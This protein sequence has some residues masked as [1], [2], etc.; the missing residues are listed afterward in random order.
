MRRLF[1][2]N[3]EMCLL[4][5]HKGSK[6]MIGRKIDNK[7]KRAKRGEIGKGRDKKKQNIEEGST[8]Q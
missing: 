4:V 1:Y 2:K 5:F 6:K 8:G 3:K 7:N